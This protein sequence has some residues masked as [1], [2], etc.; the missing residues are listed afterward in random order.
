MQYNFR[1]EEYIPNEKQARRRGYFWGLLTGIVIGA[2]AMFVLDPQN[3]RRRRSLARDQAIKARNTVDRAITEDLPK[4]AEYLSGFAEGA[5]H[6]ATEMADGRDDRR[7][8]NEPVLVDR[9]LSTVFRDPELPKGDVNIDA[10]GTTIFM[11]GS[12]ET[13]ELAADIEKRVRAVEGVDDVVNLINQP[14][15]DP[16]ELRV[17]Q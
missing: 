7:P 2:V 8:E 13:D 11:R 16:S 10:N 6:R 15:A 17:E 1:A 14:D 12:V 3:G 5:I 9:V 4:R